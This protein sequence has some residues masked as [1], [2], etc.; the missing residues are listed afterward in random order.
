MAEAICK[1]RVRGAPAIGITAAYGADLAL[2]GPVPTPLEVVQ[3]AMAA[4]WTD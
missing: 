3:A 1:L 4:C 2:R